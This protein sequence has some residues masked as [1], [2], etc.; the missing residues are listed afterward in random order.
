ML[1]EVMNHKIGS[2][3]YL[4]IFA[5]NPQLGG[6]QYDSSMFVLETNFLATAQATIIMTARLISNQVRII[7]LQEE[8]YSRMRGA[9]LELANL[10]DP[11][12]IV[13]PLLLVRVRPGPCR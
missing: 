8:G 3:K 12:N 2:N 5:R 11:A 10:F 6:A 9:D 1:S 7:L 13:R 4:A